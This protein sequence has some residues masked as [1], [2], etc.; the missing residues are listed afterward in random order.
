MK[1][2]VEINSRQIFEDTQESEKS[3]CIGEI[4]YYNKGAILEFTEKHEEQELKFKMSIL[5][6]KI[7]TYRNNQSLIFDL[8]H[9]SKS[10]LTTPYGE[11]KINVTTKKINIVKLQEQIKEINLE[12]EIELEN[13]MKYDN[14]VDIVVK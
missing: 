12:Y 3:K 10:T 13:G 14:L 6:N 4:T 7:I 1:V 2:E 9:K 8:E 5:E 11:I